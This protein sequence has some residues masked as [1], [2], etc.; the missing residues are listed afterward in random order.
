MAL[1]VGGAGAAYRAGTY[2]VGSFSMRSGSVAGTL[3]KAVPATAP[4]G[5]AVKTAAQQYTKNNCRKN[6]E[7]FTGISP[8][9]D[10]VHAHHVFPQKFR[11]DFALK[12]I[13]IDDPRYLTWWEKTSHLKTSRD[14]NK[15]WEV[16]LAR[17][18]NATQYQI[19]DIGKE[20]I[21]E[22]GMKNT[23]LRNENGI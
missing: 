14:Y 19:L 18:K 22:Y 2:A 10:K 15:R 21:S 6:L 16:A 3:S 13:N 8:P 17:T 12:G 11:D 20:I 7:R 9:G 4:A 1:M 5:T 23:L